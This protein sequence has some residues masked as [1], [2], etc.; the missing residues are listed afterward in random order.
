MNAQAEFLA[1][2]DRLE[3]EQ[4]RREEEEVCVLSLLEFDK[5]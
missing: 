1:K 2:K 5:L 3:K 4:I